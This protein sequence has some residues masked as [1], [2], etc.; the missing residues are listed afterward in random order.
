MELT[1]CCLFG[2]WLNP[3]MKVWTWRSQ[4]ADNHPAA[5]LQLLPVEVHESRQ[6]RAEGWWCLSQAAD[7]TKAGDIAAH[8]STNQSSVRKK[9][10]DCCC[11]MCWRPASPGGG[12]KLEPHS[13]SSCLTSG[14]YLCYCGETWRQWAWESAQSRKDGRYQI[15]P[16]ISCHFSN[17]SLKHAAKQQKNSL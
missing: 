12:C 8:Q 1:P 17:S 9:Q 4:P 14:P 16:L 11:W 5:G 15:Q 7:G 2:S 10:F 6:C 3:V 13:S